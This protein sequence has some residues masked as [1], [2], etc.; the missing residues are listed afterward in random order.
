M[1]RLDGRE[2][3][4]EG[5]G[6]WR[7]GRGEGKKRRGIEGREGYGGGGRVEVEVWRGELSD[8]DQQ[9]ISSHHFQRW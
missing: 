7:E 4:R 3:R 1:G 8:F 9:Y 2:K 5:W 6:G